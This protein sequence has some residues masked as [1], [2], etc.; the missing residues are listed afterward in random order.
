M[1]HSSRVEVLERLAG[2]VVALPRLHPTR[3]G[4]DGRSAAG[5]TT[6]ADDLAE[7]IAARGRPTLRASLDDFHR[8]GHKFRSMREEWTPRSY[9]EEGYDYEAFVRVLLQPLGPGGD[10]RCRTGIF[11]SQ[12]DEP[13]PEVWREVTRDA[14]AL[15]DGAYLARLELA[16][17]WDF[18]IWLDVDFETVVERARRRD[19]AWVGSEET[20]VRRYRKRAIPS[21]ELYERETGARRAASA[22]VDN[23]DASRPRILKLAEP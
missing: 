6:L 19:V 22:I 18:T 17:H 10:R 14:V 21:H 15:V 3:V 20:V 7:V 11:D 9:Y 1:A 2:A 4:V 23:R 12:R 5:K 16:P 8:P 13:L